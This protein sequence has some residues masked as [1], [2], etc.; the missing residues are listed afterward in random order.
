MID[1]EGQPTLPRLGRMSVPPVELTEPVRAVL[2]VLTAIGAIA[3]AAGAFVAPPRMWASWLLLAFYMVGL[4]LA[5]LC[6]VAIHY[7][8]GSTWRPVVPVPGPP[9]DP[10]EFSA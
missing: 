8:T 2:V 10:G 7:T 6:F 9:H 5:G 4:G 1:A 3:A